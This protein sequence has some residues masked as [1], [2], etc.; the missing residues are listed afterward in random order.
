MDNM[1]IRIS[2]NVKH[3]LLSQLSKDDVEGSQ[4][5]IK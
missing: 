3:S 4:N 2:F 5:R 1:V